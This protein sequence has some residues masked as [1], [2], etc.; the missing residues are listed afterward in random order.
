IALTQT[1]APKITGISPTNPAPG[2]SMLIS[3]SGLQVRNVTVYFSRQDGFRIGVPASHGDNQ[4]GVLVPPDA[5]EGPI[6]IGAQPVTSAAVR[7]APFPAAISPKLR[8]RPNQTEVAQ[9]EST[10]IAVAFLFDTRQR[11]LRWTSTIGSIDETG[12]F[13]APASV[14]QTE[15]A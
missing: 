4:V 13:A 11:P 5:V 12:R 8:M 1:E 10:A 14:S 6:E 3:T 15:Y 2:D 9:G 7:T